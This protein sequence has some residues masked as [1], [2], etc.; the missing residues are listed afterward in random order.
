M[1]S[2]DALRQENADFLT[3][4][5]SLNPDKQPNIHR[6]YKEV[7]ERNRQEIEANLRIHW[8]TLER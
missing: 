5:R 2:I 3:L 7:I 8:M 4:L 6:Y 1:D